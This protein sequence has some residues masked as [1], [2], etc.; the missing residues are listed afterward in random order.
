MR[1]PFDLLLNEGGEALESEGLEGLLSRQSGSVLETI[2]PPLLSPLA[3][4]ADHLVEEGLMGGAILGGVER[5]IREGRC[6]ARQL[7]VFEHGD[8]L[9]TAGHCAPPASKRS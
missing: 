4:G 9:L 1:E 8:E 6:H 7:E 3:L 5:Q 2:D